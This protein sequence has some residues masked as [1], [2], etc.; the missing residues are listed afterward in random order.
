M[1]EEDPKDTKPK[2]DPKPTVIPG[3][4]IL[5][6]ADGTWTVHAR[7]ED[8]PWYIT[9]FESPWDAQQW[10]LS[11]LTT[12]IKNANKAHLRHIQQREER[13][14]DRKAELVK[15]MLATEAASREWEVKKRGGKKKE[16]V[17]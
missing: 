14:A 10:V 6:I 11:Y 7:N 3:F 17:H 15:L 8:S 5:P 16:Q 1:S 9:S 2:A 12:N 4:E 13:E